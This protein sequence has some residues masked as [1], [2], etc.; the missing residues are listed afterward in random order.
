MSIAR[1]PVFFCAAGAAGWAS[2]SFIPPAA[3]TATARPPCRISRRDNSCLPWQSDFCFM[4]LPPKRIVRNARSFVCL[5][6]VLGYKLGRAFP[7]VKRDASKDDARAFR[8]FDSAGFQT[9]LAGGC[10]CAAPVAVE[11]NART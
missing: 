9:A 6:F 1:A 5:A 8:L 2:A 4:K 10:T 11:A 3:V 7:H